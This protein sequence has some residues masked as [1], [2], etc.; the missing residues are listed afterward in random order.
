MK[1]GRLRTLWIMFMSVYLILGVSVRAIIKSRFGTLNRAWCDHTLNEWSTKTLALLNVH[2]HIYNPNQTHVQAGVP[3][4]IVCNHTSHYDIPLSFLAF[5]NV[6]LRM[7]AK[8]ELAKIPVWGHA[9]L[10][11]E[12]PTVNR[13]DRQ[14]AIQD[15]QYVQELLKSGI[16][17]W[18]APEGTRSDDGTLKPFKKGAFITAIQT[19]ATIIPIV[20]RGANQ[21]LP[22]RT[23]QFQLNQHAEI[24]IGTPVNTTGYSLDTKQ[25][26]IDTVFAQMDQLLKTPNK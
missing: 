23:W 26:L 6:S 8:H 5:P 12:F 3:T 18:I 13:Q 16:V 19:Q 10:K 7:L 21:I 4:I 14:K 25:E 9:M 11:S 15:L 24:H 20:I 1:A 22:P 2:Y 17:M